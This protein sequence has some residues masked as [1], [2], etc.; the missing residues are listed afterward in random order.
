[1]F[2]FAHFTHHQRLHEV[3]AAFGFCQD[4]LNHIRLDVVARD[5]SYRDKLG[6]AHRERVRLHKFVGKSIK[7]LMLEDLFD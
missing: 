6:E 1:M 3:M 4:A 5:K 7:T 2:K